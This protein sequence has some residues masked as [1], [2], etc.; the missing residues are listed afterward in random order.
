MVTLP[1]LP[2]Q[3]RISVRS[4]LNQALV[5]Y[6]ALNEKVKLCKLALVHPDLPPG[7]VNDNLVV[8]AGLLRLRLDNHFREVGRAFV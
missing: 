3:V 7:V 2:Q 6:L 1:K 8:L 5:C 4:L